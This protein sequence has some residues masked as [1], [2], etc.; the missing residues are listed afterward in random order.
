MK[1]D[2]DKFETVKD[3]FSILQVNQS[4][5]YVN[6]INRVNQ[7]YSAMT[8]D[9]FPV[10]YIHSSMDKNERDNALQKFKGWI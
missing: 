1:D 3:L 9:G 8:A 7:L 4:I 5:T 10:G 2:N 6:T